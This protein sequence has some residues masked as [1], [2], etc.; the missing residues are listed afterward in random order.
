[1]VPLRKNKHMKK[2]RFFVTFIF[3]LLLIFSSVNAVELN[4]YGI[5][6]VKDF[7]LDLDSNMLWTS[8]TA[9]IS[10][11]SESDQIILACY[12]GYKKAKEKNAEFSINYYRPKA[13]EIKNQQAKLIW[14]GPKL[15]ELENAMAYGDLF[16]DN[17]KA[18]YAIYKNRIEQYKYNGKKF[19][20]QEF[21]LPVLYTPKQAK[22]GDIDNDGKNE[23]VIFV[24]DKEGIS[25][26]SSEK[27]SLI[28][29]KPNE[30][31]ELTV[32]YFGTFS[33]K[34]GQNS[35]SLVC[36]DDIYNTGQN[37]LVIRMGKADI[38]PSEY[39]ILSFQSNKLY[40]ERVLDQS[41]NI[42]LLDLE[43]TAHNPEWQ[44]KIKNDFSIIKLNGKNYLLAPMLPQTA[45]PSNTMAVLSLTDKKL[46]IY[47]EIRLGS[48]SGALNILPLNLSGKSAN[49]NLLYLNDSGKA[50]V[51]SIV[52]LEE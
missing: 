11:L 21:K 24:S 34:G 12:D 29:Y 51:Y 44:N 27:L 20:K 26:A 3:I 39:K 47:A 41:N 42:T 30:K 13:F 48:S 18:F 45:N 14:T 17:T 33:Y 5:K 35:D 1:V 15:N 8:F 9:P 7:E 38:A 25:A 22:I 6:L 49:S 52:N 31:G 16:G 19:V 32:A 46:I 23:L 40:K 36:I 28:I 10:S 37:K 4:T 43:D 50:E 2:T